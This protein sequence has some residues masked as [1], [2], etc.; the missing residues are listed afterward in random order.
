MMC[1]KYHE[2]CLDRSGNSKNLK[3]SKHFMMMCIKYHEI[4]LDR[5]RNSKD[6][7]KFKTFLDHVY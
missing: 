2:I 1:I 4:C 3:N 5:S 7:K 6:S